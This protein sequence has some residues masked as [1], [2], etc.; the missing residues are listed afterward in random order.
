MCVGCRQR[1]PRSSLVRLVLAPG[2][3]HRLVV[4]DQAARLPGRGA[5][6]HRDRECARLALKRRPWARA[7]RHAGEID[8]S[9]VAKM[10][11]TSGLEQPDQINPS[12]AGGKNNG[13]TMS[14]LK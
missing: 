1:G 8:V 5:W 6:L 3:T 4:V 12:K 14:A 9:A 13:H 11:A 7:W 10:A 2:A